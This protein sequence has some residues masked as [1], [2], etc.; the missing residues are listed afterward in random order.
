MCRENEQWNIV[1]EQI[2][3]RSLLEADSAL[4][5]SNTALEDTAIVGRVRKHQL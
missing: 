1:K 4:I 5:L 2:E 3:A